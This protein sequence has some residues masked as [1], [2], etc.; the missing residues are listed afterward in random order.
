MSFTVIVFGGLLL[1]FLG[2]IA[3]GAWNPKRLSEITGKA[4]ERRWATQ[5]QIEEGDVTEMVDAQNEARRLRGKDEV[6]EAEVRARAD[7]AQR[8]SIERAKGDEAQDS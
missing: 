2:L 3:L 5:A 4:D 6:S 1:L 7:E 8:A